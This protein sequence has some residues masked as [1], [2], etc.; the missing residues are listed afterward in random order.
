MS[1]SIVS[2]PTTALE[3]SSDESTSKSTSAVI[4]Q[5][6]EPPAD[7]PRSPNKLC[8]LYPTEDSNKAELFRTWWNST[9][10]GI[11]LQTAGRQ[12][13]WGNKAQDGKSVWSHF[14]D[15]A[16]ILQGAPKV[17]CKY[18]WRDHT[19]PSIKNSGTSTLRKHI[20]SGWCRKTGKR[21]LSAQLALNNLYKKAKQD[22]SSPSLPSF[23]QSTFQDYLFSFILEANLPFRLVEHDSFRKLLSLCRPGIQTPHQTYLKTTLL[24]RFDAMQKGLLDD[25]SSSRKLSLALD[26]WKSPNHYSFLAIT[27]YFI[28]DDWRYCEVLLAFKPLHGKHSAFRLAEYVMETLA[29]YNITKRLLTITADNVKNNNTLRKQLHK[30]LRKENIEWDYRPS[31]I[32]CMS[33]TIQLSVLKFLSVLKIQPPNDEPEKASKKQRYD[34]ISSEDIGYHN[35]YL[36]IR[37]LVTA[38]NSSPQRVQ[39]FMDLQNPDDRELFSSSSHSSQKVRLVQDVTTRWESSY[40]MVKTAW[41]LKKTIRRWLIAYGQERFG[42]LSIQDS[43]WKKIEDILRILEPFAILTSLIGTTLQVSVHSVFRS[44]NWLFDRIGDITGELEA[45][46]GEATIELL[47]A[48][49]VAKKRLQIYYGKN[50]GI[51]GRFFN[52]ATIL[53]PS[54]R[55]ELYNDP[56]WADSK[57]EYEEEFRDH[58]Q[59]YYAHLCAG[60]QPGSTESDSSRPSFSIATIGRPLSKPL[61]TRSELDCYLSDTFCFD[62]EGLLQNPLEMW[63]KIE[64]KYPIIANMAKDILSIP[65]S[66]VGIERL[67]NTARDVCFYRGNHPN[68]STIEMIMLLKWNEKLGLPPSDETSNLFDKEGSQIVGTDEPWIDEQPASVKEEYVDWESESSDESMLDS[69]Y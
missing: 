47:E 6:D 42:N 57:K 46:K 36:K 8:V 27:G 45:K 65:A 64:P 21:P 44:F 67:F 66:G 3:S 34:H 53:D 56:S 2:R 31:T 18:C 24:Q 29:F 14:V 13:K 48:L 39:Q 50:S 69:F 59:A 10:Y 61:R 4:G 33:H 22:Q 49:N 15:G 30:L 60:P 16:N 26:C 62:D 37:S 63:K 9:P 20:N 51:Y 7:L 17:L 43:E 25:L 5:A 32:R 58:F 35:T 41:E 54:I 19:H 40:E 68:L 52:L 55:L 28:S 38:I 11:K 1:S 12:L 23:S